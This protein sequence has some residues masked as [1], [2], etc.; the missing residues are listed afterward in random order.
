M[1]TDRGLPDFLII[2]K[3][4]K[5]S[6]NNTMF[7]GSEIVTKEKPFIRIAIEH[8]A[9]TLPNQNELYRDTAN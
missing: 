2:T 7:K 5:M 3:F 4:I 6:G 8:I 9:Y 1:Y